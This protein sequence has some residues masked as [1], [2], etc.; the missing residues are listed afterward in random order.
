MDFLREI[1]EMLDVL[2]SWLRDGEQVIFSEQ[3]EAVSAQEGVERPDG[4][5][6]SEFQSSA[7]THLESWVMLLWMLELGERGL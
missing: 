6:G 7:E 5:R 3:N 4:T 1:L 2:F